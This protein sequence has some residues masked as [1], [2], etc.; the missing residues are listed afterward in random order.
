MA[1][2]PDGTTLPHRLVTSCAADLPVTGAGLAW[3]TDDGPAGTFAA[4]DGPARVMEELQFSLGEGPC[5]DSS[6]MG[7]PVLQA[8]LARTG[9][10]RWPAFTAGAIDAGIRAIFALP[11]QVGG[12]RLGVLDL[13][14]DS[15]GS[16]ERE[17][18]TDALSYADAATVILLHLQTDAATDVMQLHTAEPMDY[19]AEVHQAT[20]MT[21]AQLELSLAHSLAL[22]RAYAYAAERL[23]I[24][25]ANDVVA[26]RLRLEK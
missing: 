13:Y 8:D 19:H 1:G 12:I 16:L 4:T 14:R 21:A 18:L 6:A 5:V 24:D 3:M 15:P 20:G 17:D 23:V 25:V 22:L 9:M 7:S 26:R 2:S 10:A 11:L